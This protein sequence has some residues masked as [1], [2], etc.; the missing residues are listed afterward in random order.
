MVLNT[1]RQQR[2]HEFRYLL[3]RA[4][5]SRRAWTGILPEA[6]ATDGKLIRRMICDHQHLAFQSFEHSD[7]AKNIIDGV[8]SSVTPG[9]SLVGYS[10]YR[11][12]ERVAILYTGTQNQPG[13]VA[14]GQPDSK[15]EPR[16]TLPPNIQRVPR[17]RVVAGASLHWS[18]REMLIHAAL[19]QRGNTFMN[20]PFAFHILEHLIRWEIRTVSIIDGQMR[21]VELAKSPEPI[22]G[23]LR[24]S[25]TR[26]EGSFA[27]EPLI[28][29]EM[30]R[31]KRKLWFVLPF[32]RDLFALPAEWNRFWFE[33]DLHE[34]PGMLL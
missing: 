22:D 23:F 20:S 1:Y 31:S 18:R 21:T 6:L 29:K 9:E 17:L 34:P 25:S 4:H 16:H 3:Y 24:V 13:W 8:E 32:D 27:I 15:P 14:F 26:V 7:T 5:R 33:V 12:R 30:R 28:Y 19:E 11:D 2:A 10:A